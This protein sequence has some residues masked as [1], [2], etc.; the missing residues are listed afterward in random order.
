MY[1]MEKALIPYPQQ[2]SESRGEKKIGVLS[3]GDFSLQI[4]AVAAPVFSEAC[5]LLFD[6]LREKAMILN[7]KG[8]YPITFKVDE[9]EPRL[10][11]LKNP[12]AYMI[13][14]TE[15][16]ALLCGASPAGALYAAVTFSQ[17]LHVEGEGL[18]LP[19]VT[20][21]D[22]P[23]FDYRSQYME[24]RFGS[25]F[26][27]REE[28]FELIDYLVS[29]KQNHLNLACY[30]CWGRQYDKRVSEYLY[31]P[32]EKYPQLKTPRDVKYYSIEKRKWIYKHEV[33]P[34]LF[35]EDSLGEV[36]DYGLKK[37]VKVHVLFNS[38]GHNTLLPRVFPELSA[39]DE[40]GNPRG[41]GVCTEGEDTFRIMCDLYDEIIDRYLLP[42]GIDSIHLGLDEVY[43]NFC[44]CEACRDLDYQEMTI[45]YIIKICQYLKKKGI[46]NVY[47]YHD[48]LFNKTNR[49][50]EELKQ[51]F[52]DADI[53]DIVVIDWWSYRNEQDIFRGHLKDINNLFRGIIKPMTGYYHWSVP[54]ENSNNLYICAKKAKEMG[55]EGMEPYGSYEYS[56]DKNFHY[57]ADLVWNIETLEHY[58]DFMKRYAQLRFPESPEKALEAL[59]IMNDL[60]S[61]D[62]PREAGAAKG[63]I[64]ALDKTDGDKRSAFIA[65]DET[66]PRNLMLTE[67]DFYPY[68]YGKSG[69]PNPRNFPGEVFE[70]IEAEPEKM[71]GYLED[72]RKKAKKAIEIF[73]ECG[74]GDK[75]RDAWLLIAGQYYVTSNEYLSLLDASRAYESGALDGDGLLAVVSGLL[76]DRERLMKFTE[77]VRLEANQYIYLRNMSVYRQYLSDLRDYVKACLKKGE[78]PKLDLLDLGYTKSK[79]FDFIR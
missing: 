25:D 63:D 47:I 15:S 50:N 37:N 72:T 68:I 67:F 79:I 61:D 7:P 33:L 21:C 39:K 4:E 54:T 30:G 55:Y 22:W 38:F 62:K 66:I 57:A 16:G 59:A 31:I 10:A 60:M 29:L 49:I 1:D 77:G 35:E 19:M 46:K 71:L 11:K 52:I 45:R 42:R 64:D 76:L 74:A 2:M 5:K 32:F 44:E 69:K 23:S 17:L 40:Q 26:M 24:C 51:R 14:I 28:L 70:K 20:I 13:D 27:G 9:T 75:V 3:C 8:S 65:D 18:Y 6:T 48:M 56:Y 36:I 12:E 53:Y 34:K 41:T 78:T 58:D 43:G 73:K